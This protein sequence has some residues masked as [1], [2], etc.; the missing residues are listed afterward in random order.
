M[1]HKTH[2][3]T[4]CSTKGGVG[5]T[6]LAANMAA[7]FAESGK[8]TL[9]IDADTQPSLSRYFPVAQAA[10]GG[11]NELLRTASWDG[12][13]SSTTLPNLDLVYSNDPDGLLQQFVR[14][15]ADGRFRLRILLQQLRGYDVVLI[16]TQ[17]AV[18]ALQ[19][20]AMLAADVLLSP[21]PPDAVTV[22][23]FISGLPAVVAR[24]SRLEAMGIRLPVIQGVFTRVENTADARAVSA[25]L[26]N[27]ATVGQLPKFNLLL[28]VIPASVAWK[29]SASAQVP[30]WKTRKGYKFYRDVEGLLVELGLLSVGDTGQ[31][32]V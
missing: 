23:E 30:V 12:V 18:G 26:R 1:K 20:S 7:F 24:L 9:I 22:R 8:K 5:K 3:I 14:D 19:E 29:A 27:A 28:S 13:I 15:E 11:L 16:D 21:L 25:L 32:G 4:F 10:A 2:I 17:G 31:G 6:T